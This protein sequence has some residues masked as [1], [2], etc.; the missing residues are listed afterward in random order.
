VADEAVLNIVV[1]DEAVLN[2]V[3][4][5]KKKVYRSK[6][7]DLSQNVTDPEYFFERIST[8]PVRYASKILFSFIVLI[9]ISL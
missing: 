2:I 9:T 6:D 1:A 7:P 8:L 5:Y 4:K 3:R